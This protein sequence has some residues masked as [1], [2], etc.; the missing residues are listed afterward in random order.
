MCLTL[1]TLV[2]LA[3]SGMSYAAQ[4]QQAEAQNAYAQQNAIN[5]NQAAVTKY[6]AE[7]SRQR[8][9]AANAARQRQSAYRDTL[10]AQGTA[11]A[12]SQNEGNSTT[13]TLQD[14]ARQGAQQIG[15]I[16]ANQSI[17]KEQGRDNLNSIH[18]E[19]KSRI[20]GVQTTSGPSLL[21]LAVNGLGVIA[22]GSNSKDYPYSDAMGGKK[23]VTTKSYM[24]LT[25]RMQY[26][27]SMANGGWKK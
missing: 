22:T 23:G 11:L 7:L 3:S 19:A 20:A 15:L 14:L 18:Q 4:S 21:S 6:S 13:M 9:E 25:D 26:N 16:D 8:E 1:G 2:G 17:Q 10:N 27:K 24:D 5:A 12:S